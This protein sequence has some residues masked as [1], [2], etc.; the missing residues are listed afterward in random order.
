MRWTRVLPLLALLGGVACDATLD[1]VSDG[2]LQATAGADALQLLNV[3]TQ[4]VHYA[5]FAEEPGGGSHLF[6]ACAGP[7]CPALGRGAVAVVPYADLGGYTPDT[8]RAVVYWW[9][10]VQDAEGVWIADSIRS[11]VVPLRP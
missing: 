8:Q 6:L 7:G 1:P 3:G 2:P 4:P 11:F 5:V 9:Y 10:S